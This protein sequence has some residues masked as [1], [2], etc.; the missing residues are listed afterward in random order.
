L[1][2]IIFTKIVKFVNEK[3]KN[4]IGFTFLYTSRPLSFKIIRLETLLLS[5]AKVMERCA[6]LKL[7]PSP[8]SSPPKRGERRKVMGE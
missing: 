4:K 3:I 7:P 8:F 2:E 6:T 1:S 5:F